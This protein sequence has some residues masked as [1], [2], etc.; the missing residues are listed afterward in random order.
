MA[1][2]QENVPPAH[3]PRLH[4]STDPYLPSRPAALQLSVLKR[5][6]PPSTRLP[7]LT[8]SVSAPIFPPTHLPDRQTFIHTLVTRPSAVRRLPSLTHLLIHDLTIV[9]HPSISF[10]LSI[11]KPVHVPIC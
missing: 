4:L 8:S 1:E 3:H 2:R 11:H 10:Q 6:L 5:V 9:C 7:I